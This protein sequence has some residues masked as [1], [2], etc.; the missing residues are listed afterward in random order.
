MIIVII[1]AGNGEGLFGKQRPFRRRC[2]RSR[3]SR[4]SFE[5]YTFVIEAR[6]K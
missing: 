5:M 2:T 4:I 3:R 6:A 1:K